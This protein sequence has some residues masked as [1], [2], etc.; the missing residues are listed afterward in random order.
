[1]KKRIFSFLMA[2]VM[3]IGL[4]PMSTWAAET[5]DVS[6][7]SDDEGT[8][9][10]V[11][12]YWIDY[13]IQMEKQEDG[14]YTGTCNLEGDGSLKHIFVYQKNEST[15]QFTGSSFMSAGYIH[16]PTTVFVTYSV[17]GGI[18]SVT[19]TLDS[20]KVTDVTLHYYGESEGF[21][22][23]HYYFWDLNQ[24]SGSMTWPGDDSLTED[25]EHPGWYTVTLTNL[26]APQGIGIIFSNGNGGEGNQTQNILLL[27]NDEY[28]YDGSL[29]TEAPSTWVEEETAHSHTWSSAW[30]ADDTHHWHECTAEGCDVTDNANKDGYGEHSYNDGQC[31]CGATAAVVHSHADM[32][33]TQWTATDRLPTEAGNYCLTADVTLSAAWVP[34]G[35]TSICLNGHSITQAGGGACITVNS[36]VTLDI[37]DCRD[38]GKITHAKHGEWVESGNGVSINGGS[39]TLHNGSICGNSVNGN[40]GGVSINSGSFTMNGGTISDNASDDPGAGGGV[41]VASGTTFIMHDGIISGNQSDANAG[42]VYNAGTFTMTGGSITG[43]TT[44]LGGGVANVG[45]FEMTGGSIT[46]NTATLTAGGVNQFG[47]MTVSGKAVI[48]D[49]LVKAKGAE[50]GTPS[51]M[52]T[53]YYEGYENLYASYL[54]VGELTEGASIGVTRLS[55]DPTTEEF[56]SA[57]GTISNAAAS[58]YIGYFFADDTT[59]KVTTNDAG[60]LVLTKA[61]AEQ[62]ALTITGQP[63]GT[64]YYGD[65][66][67]LSTS[68]GSGS[69]AVTWAVTEGGSFATV[70]STGNVKITGVGQVTVTATKAGD[71]NYKEAVASYTFT[72]QKATP[73]V[74]TVTKTSPATIYPNTNTIELARTDTTVPGTLALDAG[75][76]LTL[77]EKAY[78]WTFTPTDSANYN[79]VKGTIS[80]EVT[81]DTLTGISASGNLSKTAYVYGEPFDPAGL[82]VTATYASTLTADV[83]DKVTFSALKAGDTTVLLSYTEGSVTQTCTVDITVAKA[84]LSITADSYTVT[85]GDPL[86]TLTYQVTGLVNSDTYTNPTLSTTA[87][88]TS[89]AGTFDITVSGGTLSNAGC[90]NVTYQKGALTVT[91][92]RWSDKWSNDETHHWHECLD[93]SCPITDNSKKDGYG[94]H[95][96]GGSTCS[97]CGYILEIEDVDVRIEQTAITQVPAGLQTTA[98]NT[99]AK[100]EAELSRVLTTDTGYAAENVATFDVMLQYSTDGGSTWITATE[101]NFPSEGI[102]VTLPYPTGTG[103]NT[104][105]FQVTHMFTV[106]SAKLGITAGE[107]EQPAVTKT[108][109]GIRVTL[110]G[111]SPVG[112]SWKSI[113]TD[114]DR[115]PHKH[116]NKHWD[117]DGEKDRE[118]DSDSP[119]TGDITNSGLWLGLAALGLLGLTV[120]LAAKKRYQKRK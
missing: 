47:T 62:A 20:G 120:T 76:T 96:S 50:T 55:V 84:A 1:M 119:K 57:G 41:Y 21:T 38:S 28:W 108:D 117:R 75:Q 51:N 63:T 70:D 81:K 17:T 103:R 74:G 36:G 67:T 99:V 100:I 111:L 10:D 16:G 46:G 106:T 37:H 31:E 98:F 40:G 107:T 26:D 9:E 72:S 19:N 2:L 94:A 89:A 105:D 3:I 80:L 118:Y 102:T 7:I 68:G 24:D 34:V 71:G 66:F 95:S 42:G 110:K 12:T 114:D 113:E 27:A 85:L 112:I 78:S 77:G 23:S 93:T 116:W 64:I 69:G 13:T 44:Q 82:T 29:R 49:N 18:L 4:L 92:H 35:T 83:T 91:A 101:A 15:G 39:V 25:A 60:Y 104:H 14:T 43:N 6:V 45:T 22:P 58:D 11:Y 88:D 52:N 79:E 73:D 56:A 8:T 61:K 87:S 32:T 65:T 86:P 115:E 30:A 97:I 5:D 54:T 48:K 59:Y 109:S 90:Y 53:M 33:F